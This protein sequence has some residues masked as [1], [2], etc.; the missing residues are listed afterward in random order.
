[1]EEP[2]EISIRCAAC[3]PRE[4]AP[5]MAVLLRYACLNCYRIAI[6]EVRSARYPPLRFPRV[7]PDGSYDLD[8]DE[9]RVEGI[10]FEHPVLRNARRQDAERHHEGRPRWHLHEITNDLRREHF[11]KH[12]GGPAPPMRKYP[13]RLSKPRDAHNHRTR[14]GKGVELRCSRCTHRPREALRHLYELADQAVL[15]NEWV[16]YL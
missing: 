9:W 8:S 5:A 16:I 6:V 1:M 12:Y 14:Q 2:V 3:I 15:D 10:D 11:A 7:L 13:M 4:A